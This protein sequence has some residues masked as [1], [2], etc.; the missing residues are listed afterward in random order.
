MANRP[1]PMFPEPNTENFWAGAKE[2]ELRYQVCD[3]CNS[4]VFYPRQ[5]C[6]SCLSDSLSWK[7]SQGC[8]TVYTF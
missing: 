7:V 4:V 1:Q 8:G 3:D 6:P 5:H 2:G